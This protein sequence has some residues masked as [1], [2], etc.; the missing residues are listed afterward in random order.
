M[1]TIIRTPGDGKCGLELIL[2]LIQVG[3]E[4]LSAVLHIF[5]KEKETM[6]AN[7]FKRIWYKINRN[8]KDR[9]FCKI[10][11]R[12]KYKKYALELYNAVNGSDYKSLSDLEIITLEDAVYIKMKNDVAYLVSGTIAIYEHQS[13]VNRNMLLRGF[14]YMGELYGKIL[15]RKKTKIYNTTLVRIPAPQYIVFYNGKD[16]Y[17]EYSKLRLSDAFI[18]PTDDHDYEFTAIVYNINCGRNKKL[19]DFCKPLWGYSFLIDRIQTNGRTM[20]VE[21]AV[22]EAV[23]YCIANG[24]LV[25]VLEEERSAVMLEMLTYFDEKGYEEGLREEAREE[26]RKEGREEERANTERERKRADNAEARADDLR[27]ELEKYRSKYGSL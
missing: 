17:P 3:R 11:G 5:E 22:D 7:W 21:D 6:K 8:Y 20:P 25:D 24:I 23:R 26:G 14:M 10:F 12:E 9:L 1:I 27:A 15:K 4:I 19:L 16:D 2:S 18:I 13:S